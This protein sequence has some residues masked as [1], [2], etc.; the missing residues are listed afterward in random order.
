M[1][2][3]AWETAMTMNGLEQS[4]VPA[5]GNHLLRPILVATRS[6]RHISSNEYSCHRPAG[7]V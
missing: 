3:E 5:K 7:V 4:Y 2:L 6:E 1:V